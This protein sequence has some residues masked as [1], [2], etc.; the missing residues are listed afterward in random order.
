VRLGREL[1]RPR[2]RLVVL[3][4][5]LCGCALGIRVLGLFLL[6]DALLVVAIYAP[7]G[8]GA[9]WRQVAGFA[10]RA[11]V[12]LAAA[13]LMAYA[14]MIAAWPW[15]GLAPLNPLRALSAFAEFHYPINTILDG[16]VYRMADVPL[17][18][19]HLY[20]HQAHAAAARRRVSRAGAGDFF[21]TPGE[22]SEPSAAEGD[23]VHCVCRA[24]SADL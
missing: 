5:V 24:L 12:A 1:P 23:D 3:F 20:R 15:A 14:I 11:A 7:A 21:A 10:A 9:A 2:W 4:G 13:F 22:R 16:Q 6:G 18:R 17:V 8:P 19:A